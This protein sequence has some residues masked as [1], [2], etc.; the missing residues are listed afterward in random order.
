MEND[1]SGENTDE[2]LS[3]DVD[4]EVD[5][6][7]LIP[8]ALSHDH[9]DVLLDAMDAQL[10]H[11][12]IHS[13]SQMHGGKSKRYEFP[14]SGYLDRSQSVSKDTGLG[15]SA[16]T[17]DKTSSNPD[18]TPSE[19][20]T[21]EIMKVGASV[22][23]VWCPEGDDSLSSVSRV[24]QCRWRLERLLGRSA[25]AAGIGNEEDEF[26]MD[27]VCTEDFSTRFR[28][29]MLVLPASAPI[30]SSDTADLT[31]ERSKSQPQHPARTPIR[32]MAGMPLQSFDSVTIDTDLDTVCSE[33]VRQHLKSTLSNRTVTHFAKYANSDQEYNPKYA[34]HLSKENGFCTGQTI[35]NNIQSFSSDDERTVEETSSEGA[36][37]KLYYRSRRHSSGKKGKRRSLCRSRRNDSHIS[38]ER[39][40]DKSRID[41]NQLKELRMSLTELL[42]QKT[43]TLHTLENL[44]EEMDEAKREKLSLQ[45]SVRDSRAQAQ[46]ITY[47]LHRLQAQRD[48]CLEEV[49]VLQEQ[50][51]VSRSVS[52]LEREEM[53]RLL[54]N[55]KSDLFSE[56]RR[57]RHTLDSMQERLDEVNQELEQREEDYRTLHQKCSDLEKQLADMIR[58]KEQIK[59]STQEDLEQQVKRFAALER[60]VAQKELLLQGAEEAKKALLLELCSLR[61]EHSLKLREIQN[62]TKKD[63]EQQIEQLTLQLTKSH[64]E[65]L[66]KVHQQA[67]ELRS[68]ALNEQAQTHK[69]SL[70][71][72]HNCIQMKDEEVKR[73]KEA[74]E[75]H[76]EK[77]TRQA[78]E[79]RR[80]TQEKIQKAVKREER[81]WEEQREKAL[82]EQRGT[83]E[84]QIEEAA[85]RWRA[86][87]EKERRNALVLQSK[88]IEL[89]KEAEKEAVRLKKTLQRSE[90]ELLELRTAITEKDQTHQRRTARHEQKSR[91]WA[92]DI[93]A[94]CVCLQEFLEHN[95]L[96]IENKLSSGSPTVSE[97]LQNLQS[98][99]KA[100]QQLINDLKME[101]NSQ[102]RAALQLTREK[103]QELKLQKEQLMEEKERALAALKE[104]LI[105]EHIE[106]MSSLS[107]A[108]LRMDN[109][110]T[111]RL[112][113]HMRRQLQAKD[114]ELRQPQNNMGPW[115]DKT[116]TRLAHKFELN[117]EQDRRVPKPRA[118]QQ[119]RLERLENEMR[120]LTGQ[121][122]D[123]NE[124]HLASSALQGG[125]DFQ[126]SRVT[127]DLTS[128]KLLQHL[129]SRIRQ[130]QAERQTHCPV[131]WDRE[132]RDLGG[133]YLD[134][135]A[136]AQESYKTEDLLPAKSISS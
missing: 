64:K 65:E 16:P 31:E 75:Q 2:L 40:R 131:K 1:G 126:N 54:D 128:Y 70:D 68:A 43:A 21:M 3:A 46:N 132:P 107:R 81:K 8:V 47:E 14:F 41:G 79:L 116:T 92:Q 10:S 15:S 88:V 9:C 109:D 53:D 100:L 110:D 129:Q 71:S 77:M 35:Q 63:M 119:K 57:F 99:T 6:Y 102:R 59:E 66:Q 117:A 24:E 52:V 56:Q 123:F 62:R 85:E 45:I 26:T 94:E 78:E 91:R 7:G 103:V 25:E 101:L 121:C 125:T 93:H 127:Q 135:I 32:H 80:K 97:T 17:N 28:E 118:D 39:A 133:S 86:E 114:D 36:V 55:A 69:Q 90:K 134:T 44:R 105:Q 13:Q 113:V 38:T 23:D 74:L 87:V 42:Q 27:S 84:Q 51:C 82:R 98:L 89:Q 34:L 83:L 61:E 73:L 111:D 11:L 49:R 29:E 72:L 18:W 112:C 67:D 22:P 122:R 136:P 48:S 95:G 115:K 5:V 12:Q 37:S 4:D 124:S 50:Q 76:E 60:I 33:Q 30:T 104:K 19:H 108:Q 58:E 20:Q 130:I 96:T 106:E 120:H